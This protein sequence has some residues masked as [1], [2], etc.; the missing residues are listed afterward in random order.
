[1]RLADYHR[2]GLLEVFRAFAILLVVAACMGGTLATMIYLPEQRSFWV[3]ATG[4]VA[5]VAA[6]AGVASI[7][8]AIRHRVVAGAALGIVVAL[9]LWLPLS[10]VAVGGIAYADFGVTV[11]GMC[12][13]PAFD[14]AF[15]ANGAVWFRAKSHAITAAEVRALAEGAERVIVATGWD[16]QARVEEAALKLEGVKV[17]VLKTGDAVEL[18]RESIRLHP[19][20]E[21]HTFLGWT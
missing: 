14:L 11:V 18:Y 5:A 15:R 1:M 13:V 3:V 8:K 6:W 12:P 20:A 21:A 7:T 10:A 4:G 9:V 19:T 16:G 17:E 2:P